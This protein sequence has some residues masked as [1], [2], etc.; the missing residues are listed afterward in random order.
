MRTWDFSKL[1][2]QAVWCRFYT[3]DRW[4]FYE[5]LK[6]TGWKKVKKV[7]CWMKNLGSERN[8]SATNWTWISPQIFPQIQ[9]VVSV[10]CFQIRTT[11]WAAPLLK[12]CPHRFVHLGS[13][14]SVGPYSRTFNRPTQ[15]VTMSD[16]GAS[17]PINA[18]PVST[19]SLPHKM[20]WPDGMRP[21]QELALDL[22]VLTL[23]GHD[24]LGGYKNING[25][26]ALAFVC[27]YIHVYI[28]I[29]LYV[30]MYVYI[31]VCI[32]IFCQCPCTN[33]VV[34]LGN[35]LILGHYIIFLIWA[36]LNN[37]MWIAQTPPMALLLLL[38]KSFLNW[39]SR[40]FI[41]QPI[42]TWNWNTLLAQINETETPGDISKSCSSLCWR[43]NA[44]GSSSLYDH[45]Q[46]LFIWNPLLPPEES[47]NTLAKCAKVLISIVYI[48][49]YM[50]LCIYI[51]FMYMYAY[52]GLTILGLVDHTQ[53][54]C[55]VCY[56]NPTNRLPKSQ[57][58]LKNIPI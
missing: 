4:P 25:A 8:W 31:Y 16:Q 21:C 36:P 51:F 56:P 40:A 35:L 39:R 13:S 55:H 45:I 5:D 46:N 12:N 3:H 20:T 30:Y 15:A 24:G 17:S 14:S 22:G 42:N 10:Q 41:F 7:I 27:V 48:Y 54:K 2:V 38:S 1:N 32:Y 19:S 52:I 28:C 44:V 53:D 58:P 50:F 11:W 43:Q 57:V 34:D 18:L 37:V 26:Y 29:Y 6:M 9:L 23:F 33:H 49:I 47:W